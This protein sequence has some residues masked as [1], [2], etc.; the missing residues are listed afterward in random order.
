[1]SSHVKSNANHPMTRMFNEDPAKIVALILWTLRPHLKNLQV[2]ITMK[3]MTDLSLAAEAF[4]GLPTVTLMGKENSIVVGLVDAKT[5]KAMAVDPKLD[6]NSPEARRMARSMAARASGED[7]IRKLKARITQPPGELIAIPNKD[8]IE[9]V[10][11]I[12]ALL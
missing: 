1:M 9:A 12:E 11:T 3:D 8:F 7:L 6:E 4:G 5:G 2:E 10:E